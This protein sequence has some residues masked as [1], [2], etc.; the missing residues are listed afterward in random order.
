MNHLGLFEGIG[1]FSLAARWI[2]WHTIAW[3]EKDS[4]C[5]Q[6]LK[7]NFPEAKGY[8][9]IKEF[10]GTAYRGSVD[11][12]T[13]GFPCQPFSVAGKRKGQEDDRFLWPEM[14]RVIDEVK[15]RWVVG[16]N[17]TG[18]IGMALNQVL[19]EMEDKGYH[20]ETY[21]LPACALNAPHRR[22]RIWIIANRL[23]DGFNGNKKSS[24]GYEHTTRGAA[25]GNFDTHVSF[26][27][28]SNANGNKRCERGLYSEG[29]ET[30]KRYTSACDAP[31][32]Q[33]TSWQDFPTQSPI[34]NG[35]DGLSAGLVRH[36]R[37]NAL[38]AGGNAIVPQ[39]A[40]ELFKA[41]ESYHT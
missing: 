2:N 6:V 26:G 3:V 36:N 25:F 33:W 19:T 8:G 5:Q 37:I 32:Y 23:R 4:F 27:F 30:S 31:S 14:L 12:I 34:C 20:T 22:D 9:D 11:I 10:D 38:K 41:I 39:V 16:E 15:P 21:I 18:L 24:E 1:G 17:V 28:T 29:F 35:N 7:K 40:F 13:G